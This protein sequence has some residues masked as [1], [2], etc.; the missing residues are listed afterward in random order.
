M[1]LSDD[2]RRRI[3]GYEGYHDA[4][5]DGS[6]KAY[7]RVYHGKLDVPT[8]GYGC[9]EGVKMGMVWTRQQAEDAFS[10]ELAKFEA[11]VNR[12]VTVSMSQN[13]FDA[14]VSLAYNIGIGG[15]AKPGFS[16]STVL[17]RLNKG[18]RVGAA[19]AFHMWNKAGGAVVNGLVQ[20]RASE[21]S[22]FQKPTAAGSAPSMPQTVSESSEK[23]SRSV[24]AA[25]ATAGTATA[26]QFVPTVSDLDKIVSTGQR[27]KGL[28]EQAGDLGS[29]LWHTSFTPFALLALLGGLYFI[30]REVGIGT[31]GRSQG[32]SSNS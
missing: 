6:C 27:V 16:T 17:K 4:L 24:V 29:W 19:K 10:K 1:N 5:P 15:K 30:W 11:A 8:I 2:G 18:D 12:L 7:Q 20:R 32:D 28:T 13:E 22:L 25:A 21:A 31:S 9:T 3:Q 26:V 14:L 23:P